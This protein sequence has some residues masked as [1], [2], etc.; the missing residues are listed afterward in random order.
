MVVFIR[1]FFPEIK[2]VNGAG[3][4]FFKIVFVHNSDEVMRVSKRFQI[5][6]KKSEIKPKY[7]VRQTQAHIKQT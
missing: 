6:Y 4:E 2:L 7:T 5:S 3:L 1:F